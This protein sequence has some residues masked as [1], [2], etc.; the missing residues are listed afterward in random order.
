MI[1]QSLPRGTHGGTVISNN[2]NYLFKT[3]FFNHYT[4]SSLL[5]AGLRHKVSKTKLKVTE[6]TEIG[7]RLTG[8]SNKEENH[9]RM[10]KTFI[11][12]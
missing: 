3:H 10:G 11:K 1:H 12:V 2:D 4:I 9:E 6:V 8:I 7:R 5:C